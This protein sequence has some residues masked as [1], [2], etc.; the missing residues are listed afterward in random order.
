MKG[1]SFSGVAITFRPALSK[2]VKYIY[3][4]ESQQFE[5][6]KVGSWTKTLRVLGVLCGIAIAAWIIV[7]LAFKYIGSPREKRMQKEM[8][9]LQQKYSYLQKN[10]N[11]TQRKLKKLQQRDNEIYRVIFEAEPISEENFKEKLAAQ[12]KISKYSNVELLAS[13]DAKMQRIQKQI[14]VQNISYDS[15]LSFIKD[16]E[17]M[18]LSIP[19]IQPVSN[20]N[21]KRIASGFGYRVDPI[22]KIRKFHAGMDFTAPQGTP[23]YATGNGTIEIADYSTGGYGNQVWINHGY[24]YRTH[25]CHMVKIKKKSG[26]VKRGE[27]IGYVGSTGKSTGPH[28]HYE[29]ERKGQK[30]DPIHFF[31]NDLAV[32]DY[33]KLLEIGQR[34]NQS[35]D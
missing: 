32:E 31:Y 18:L 21:L 5:P 26:S 28:L 25:Y 33:N 24:G 8:S 14:N 19:S 3:S 22:Y 35:F 11:V 17:A 29:V 10:I 23:I 7:A 12:R 13:I 15:L 16:K 2:K 20:K 34:S 9:T 6:H 4:K 30:I 27:V 1:L